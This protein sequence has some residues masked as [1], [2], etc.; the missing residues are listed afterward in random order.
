MVCRL[1]YTVAL[2]LVAGDSACSAAPEHEV[3]AANGAAKGAAVADTCPGPRTPTDGVGSAGFKDDPAGSWTDVKIFTTSA[4][5]ITV[6]RV[7]VVTPGARD[8]S[9]NVSIRPF[10]VCRLCEITVS[11]GPDRG[12]GPG[13][14]VQ[15]ILADEARIDSLNRTRAATDDH[16]FNE[17]HGPA[18]TLV[19]GGDTAIFLQG[20][21]GD[22]SAG[23]YFFG[24]GKRIAHVAYEADNA[25]NAE[26]RRCELERVA[27]TFRWRR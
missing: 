27:L 14:V 5:S 2:V 26:L 8:T 3:N 4:W 17:Y 23:H 13:A 7:A 6:P 19:R 10:P 16:E 21:C 12:G 15:R 25:R 9:S 22:C 18:R 11:V 24:D 20:D 1:L